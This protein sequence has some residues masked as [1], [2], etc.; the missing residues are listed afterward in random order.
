MEALAYR[1][2]NVFCEQWSWRQVTEL[3]DIRVERGLDPHALEHLWASHASM[4]QESD[5]STAC[6]VMTKLAKVSQQGFPLQHVH[7]RKCKVRL[8]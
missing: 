4:Q 8:R 7:V 5:F 6:V 3:G 2:N 1:V